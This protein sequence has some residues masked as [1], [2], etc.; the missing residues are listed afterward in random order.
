MIIINNAPEL[1]NMKENKGNTVTG[2]LILVLPFICMCI[3]IN[4]TFGVEKLCL[5]F[6]VG[7][8]ICFIAESKYSGLCGHTVYAHTPGTRWPSYETTVKVKV[9]LRPMAS[10]P[11]FLGVKHPSGTHNQLFSFL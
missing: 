4:V 8:Q 5:T 1:Y 2:I 3:Y 7:I 6:Q 11:I 10:R 9:I